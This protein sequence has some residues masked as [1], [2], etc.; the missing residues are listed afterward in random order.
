[1]L[2]NIV[3]FLLTAMLLSGPNSVSNRLVSFKFLL[4]NFILFIIGQFL[5]YCDVKSR[6]A[7]GTKIDADVAID[8]A[9]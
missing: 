8:N 3:F 5:S 2:T 6:F 4:Q 1:M 9:K 7:K